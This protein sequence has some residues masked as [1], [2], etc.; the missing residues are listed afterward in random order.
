[1][2]PGGRIDVPLALPRGV[3]LWTYEVGEEETLHTPFGA[4]QAVPVKTQRLA[5]PG[6]DLVP[7]MWFAPGLRYLPARIRIHQDADTFIDLMISRKPQLA[8]E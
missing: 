6:G 2:R 7:Q 1:L 4:V 3:S 5:R 8:A